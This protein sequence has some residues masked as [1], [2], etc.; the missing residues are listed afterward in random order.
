MA[1]EPDKGA[2]SG[3]GGALGLV[4]A[5]VATTLLGAGAGGGAAWLLVGAVRSS[6]EKQQADAAK[7]SAETL[8]YSADNAVR[9]LE[10]VITN[11]AA[12][13]GAW[14][15]LEASLVFAGK[16]PKEQDELAARV[17][18]DMLAFLR[19]LRLDQIEGPSGFLHL[20][21]DLSER[22]SIRSEGLVREVVI[23]GLVVE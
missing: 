2:D 23:S 6:I 19:T 20:R 11:L 9:R 21:E 8:A 14:I 1:A 18:E 4:L 12:P 7:A 10:P 16:P 5:L 15:R 17:A 13:A 3:K 22:A